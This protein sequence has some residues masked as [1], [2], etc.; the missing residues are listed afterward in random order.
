[1]LDA[2]GPGELPG[3][4]AFLAEDRT[5]LS[6]LE[7]HGGF[8][9]ARRTVGDRFHPFACDHRARGAAGPFVLAGLTPLGFVLEVLVG[10]ELLFSRRP[11]E[12]RAAVHAPEDPV[13]ELHRSLP[14]RGR[15]VLRSA[16]PAPAGVSSGSAC[17]PA[18]A[19]RDACRLASNRRSAS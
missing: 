10:E 8:F 19:W 14:R 17:A 3:L 2:A 11:D 15:S 6:R 1:M 9:A 12:L 7:R 13:L 4:K 5:P 16:T 18:P